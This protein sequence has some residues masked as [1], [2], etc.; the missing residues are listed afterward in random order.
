MLSMHGKII[1]GMLFFLFF[2]PFL[3]S[4]LLSLPSS[5]FYPFLPLLSLISCS[6]LILTRC[7]AA[8]LLQVDFVD[9]HG[10]CT[11]RDLRGIPHV[12]GMCDK[13]YPGLHARHFSKWISLGAAFVFLYTTLL[14]LSSAPPLPL[15]ISLFILFFLLLSD[16]PN[17]H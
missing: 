9:M 6:W 1:A 3:S 10:K 16:P 12:R 7:R 8:Q 14:S 2:F 15:L 4:R 5:L 13:S 17:I 11:M